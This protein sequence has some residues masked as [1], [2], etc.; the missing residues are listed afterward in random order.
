MIVAVFFLFLWIVVM[1]QKPL[2]DERFHYAEF[3]LLYHGHWEIKS[4]LTT[5]P[6]YHLVIAGLARV[7]NSDR[8]FTMRNIS[9]MFSLLTIPVVW[10]IGKKLG[11][12]EKEEKNRIAQ[13]IVLPLS[14]PFFFLAYTDMFSLLIFLISFYFLLAKKYK[15]SGFFI[16]LSCLVRQTNIIWL[17]FEWG[18]IFL[19]TVGFKTFST[20]AL[21]KFVKKTWVYFLGTVA[22]FVFVYL[23]DGVAV[24]DRTNQQMGFF[25]GNIYFCLFLF[26]ALFLPLHLKNVGKILEFIKKHYFL[27]LAVVSII[28]SSFLFVPRV[29]HIYNIDA[30]FLRNDFIKFVY[31]YPLALFVY[32]ILIT[33]AVFSLMVTKL[34]MKN[35]WIMYPATLLLLAPSWLIEQRYFIVPFVLFILLREKI[36]EKSERAMICINALIAIIFLFVIF[37]RKFFI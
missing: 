12:N 33:I 13:F 19:E 34:T 11:W 28:A 37:S 30:Y 36:D 18:Y 23:N 3:K 5:I 14:L 17:L 29:L 27:S 22:F 6:G 31:A 9:L 15:L 20:E 10:L 32:F 16:I 1:T 4:Y 26:F 2:A 24:G 7:L 21:L 8:L 25:L 35:A